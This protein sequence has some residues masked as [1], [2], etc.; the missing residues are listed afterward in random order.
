MD[1]VRSCFMHAINLVAFHLGE[2]G[3]FHALHHRQ[4]NF[5]PAFPFDMVG[6]SFLCRESDSRI[7]L[8]DGSEARDPCSRLIVRSVVL[9]V[10]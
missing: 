1:D 9:N 10:K 6:G 4:F 7:V 5:D 8:V 2:V 3:D